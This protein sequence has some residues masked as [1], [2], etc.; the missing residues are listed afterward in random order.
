MNKDLDKARKDMWHR[1]DEVSGMLLNMREDWES[2]E[3]LADNSEEEEQWGF[4][5][6]KLQDALYAVEDSALKFE[7]E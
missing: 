3:K 5:F 2:A 7:E 4:L 6:D 1:L